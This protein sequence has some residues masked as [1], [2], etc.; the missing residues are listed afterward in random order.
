MSGMMIETPIEKAMT[1][2]AMAA[3]RSLQKNALNWYL[4]PIRA[5]S[6]NP[7]CFFVG[8]K[9]EASGLR[10]KVFV[11]LGQDRRAPSGRR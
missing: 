2:A 1:D 5:R 8:Y 9:V 7:R 4:P 10:Q 3:G 11:A 6:F